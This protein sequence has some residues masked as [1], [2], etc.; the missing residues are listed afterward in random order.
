MPIMPTTVVREKSFEK[1][2]T[3]LWRAKSSDT[4]QISSQPFPACNTIVTEVY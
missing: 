1:K 4:N 3:G 2:K